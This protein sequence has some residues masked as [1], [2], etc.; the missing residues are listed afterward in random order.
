MTQNLNF[1]GCSLPVWLGP[2]TGADVAILSCMMRI[3]VPSLLSD[4][5]IH[6]FCVAP[7]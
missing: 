5:S 3:A 2:L 7:G 6:P 4:M 1:Y